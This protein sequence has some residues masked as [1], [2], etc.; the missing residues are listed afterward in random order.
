M[1]APKDRTNMN[2]TPCSPANS[3]L[4]GD[5]ELAVQ[6]QTLKKLV[7]AETPEGF[8]VVA[9]L[10]WA[11]NKEWYLTTRRERTKPRLFKDLKRLNDHLKEAYPTDSVEILR[12]Q[13]VPEQ[14]EP[15]PPETAVPQT[16]KKTKKTTKK[17][18]Q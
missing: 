13:E 4:E 12:N 8:Y 5:L 18:N 2:R 11:G 14:G 15:T 6:Q 1:T 10:K 17:G 9:Q 3:I 7:V 16:T